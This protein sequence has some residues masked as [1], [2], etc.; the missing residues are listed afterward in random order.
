MLGSLVRVSGVC[1]PIHNGRQ[2]RLGV[3]LL[4]PSAEWVETLEA[5]PINPFDLPT[6]SI[7]SL[8]RSSSRGPESRTPFRKITGVVTYKESQMLFAQINSE[9]VRVFPRDEIDVTPGDMV[10]VVGMAEPDGLTPKLV[11]ALV[12]KIGRTPLPAANPIDVQQLSSDDNQA[13][14]DATRGWTQATLLGQSVND[15]VQILELQ[16]DTT[17]TPFRANLPRDSNGMFS[18]PLG[19]HVRL[20]GVFKA[21]SDAVPD[22]GQVI[23][24]FEMYLN[25]PADIVVLGR[26]SWWNSRHTLWL[27]GGLGLGLFAA[28][29]WITSLRKQ[30][31]RRTRQLKVVI[32]QHEQTEEQLQAEI[33]E[34]K[35][36]E[37]EVEK[38]HKALID[39]SRQAG[40]AEVATSV[41]H[42]VGNVLNSVNVSSSI[43]TESLRKSSCANLTKVVALMDDHAADLGSF[44]ISDSKG[45]LIPSYL[46]QLAVHLE[47]ERAATL[48]EMDGLR[49]NVEHIKEVV[50]MQQ[51][52]ARVAGVTETVSI[53]GLVEEALQAD[54][55]TPNCPDGKIVCDYES[56]VSKIT[57]DKH[58]V[59][60]I[61]VNVIRNAKH[62]CAEAGRKGTLIMI[63][64]RS[65]GQR[66]SISIIDN[67]VGILP[68]NL[69]RI[70]NHGFTTRKD[71]HGFGLHSGA[72]AAHELGGSLSAQSEG[73]GLGATFTLELPAQPPK[74]HSG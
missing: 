60:Q 52:Y 37:I 33:S 47:R 14:Q 2:Q 6:R 39:T 40:M 10:E 71:G 17:H 55:A 69:T 1:A 26:P 23:T 9:A 62:A 64:V 67:G 43:V 59:L 4:V 12:K 31:Y 21:K 45:R 41:L 35:R 5:S 48:K 22:F 70:F 53:A 36:M 73:Q 15:S 50:A 68:E 28:L 32:E 24:T 13:T 8:L 72:L 38:T 56:Q 34:R 11:Q 57:V 25:S 42:N 19:S 16:Q 3:R 58:K 61:L 44:I 18:L 66:V 27:L 29:T 51:T 20:E 54:T 49:Q 65:G 63:R 46:G 74:D 30:V 7:D